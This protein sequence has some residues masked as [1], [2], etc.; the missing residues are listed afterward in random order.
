[1][2]LFMIKFILLK[3]EEEENKKMKRKIE[4]RR[5]R[6]GKQRNKISIIEF[7]LLVY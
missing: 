1:M 2:T 3:K 6:E 5:R 7:I 4:K